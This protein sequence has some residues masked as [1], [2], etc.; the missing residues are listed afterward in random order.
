MIMTTNTAST[1]TIL[2]TRMKATD[3]I[4]ITTMT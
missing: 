1:A 4:I 2:R 3:I